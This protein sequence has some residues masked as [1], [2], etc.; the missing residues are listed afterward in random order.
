MTERR[1]SIPADLI[2]VDPAGLPELA[3][4]TDVI[5]F[6]GTNLGRYDWSEMLALAGGTDV[7]A[8][9]DAALAAQAAAEAA[10]TSMISETRRNYTG[11][12]T[13]TAFN[14][15]LTLPSGTSSKVLVFVGGV[16]VPEADQTVSG[17]TV[18]LATAPPDGCPVVTFVRGPGDTLPANLSDIAAVGYDDAQDAIDTLAIDPTFRS[19]SHS[20]T[21]QLLVSSLTSNRQFTLPNSSGTL[22]L[23]GDVEEEV[24]SQLGALSYLTGTGDTF[25]PAVFFDSYGTT[26]SISETEEWGR[27]YR[28]GSLVFGGGSLNF[29]LI[30]GDMGTSQVMKLAMTGLTAVPLVTGS[31]ARAVAGGVIVKKG[32]QINVNNIVLRY[33]ATN[34]FWFFEGD[35]ATPGNKSF[36]L[37]VANVDNDIMATDNTRIEFL[38]WFI[39]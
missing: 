25:A 34:D 32:G 16:L 36:P 27:F 22:A 24:E 2:T 18:T 7:E 10:A 31:P 13:T 3:A 12:G 35:D 14:I 8:A 30:K 33:D 5:T 29:R 9:R 15:G 28:I 39:S 11:D 21:A 19:A 26:G 37:T 20:N 23:I 38:F 1:I 17:N 6:D 4:P